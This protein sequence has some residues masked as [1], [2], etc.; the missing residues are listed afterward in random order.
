MTNLARARRIDRE[1]ARESLTKKAAKCRRDLATTPRPFSTV[2]PAV[3][4]ADAEWR[5][6]WIDCAPAG[7][8]HQIAPMQ[9]K[10]GVPMGGVFYESVE[11]GSKALREAF[12]RRRGYAGAWKDAK[13]A[14][15]AARA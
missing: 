2:D 14:R 5:L 3:I 8:N 10:R 1:S 11:A 9:D 7:A 15:A 13:I 12:D 6:R 4:L